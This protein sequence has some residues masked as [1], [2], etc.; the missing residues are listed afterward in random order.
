VSRYEAG[1]I[2]KVIVFLPV[3]TKANFQEQIDTWCTCPDIE[4]KLVGEESMGSSPRTFFET[5]QY[6]DSETQII[7]D[8]SHMAKNPFAKRSKRIKV[9]CDKTSYKLVMTGTPVTE[10]V[11]NLYMQYAMLSDLI[12]GVGNWL[13][14]EEKY[15]IIGGRSGTEVIGYK[16]LDH[17]LSL[18]EPYTYQI[19]ASVLDLKA[20]DF[21]TLSCDMNKKQWEYYYMEKERLLDLI[22]KD[23]VRATD[24]FHVFTRMQQITS[25]YY[26]DDDGNK[27][28][29][30]TTKTCL[31]GNLDLTRKTVFFCKYLHEV[32]LLVNRLGAE[33]CAVFTG[34]N[35]R[36][37]DTEK[38][39]FV[40]GSKKYF[41][42]TMQSGGTGLNG[43]QLV[44]CDVVF[45]SQSFSY[46]QMKQSIGRVD[47]PGQNYEVNVY[48]FRT[49]AKIDNRILNCINC[50]ENL[51]DEIKKLINDKTKLKRY[52]EEL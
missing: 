28:I 3:S 51:S 2:R 11:H 45:F 43:L 48:Y 37:R 8:E 31:I 16:N 46:F 36:G 39:S 17:L 42:A 12:I 24:I 41:V 30:G 52:V 19:D 32:D 29:L 20:K 33:N 25:G 4:W 27:I 21:H 40:K 13:K 5:L 34:N 14:F 9:V 22:R 7:I 6:A 26:V 47:R 50:K 15:L 49:F 18:I 23:E 44:S 10:N 35:R 38:D 1:Q